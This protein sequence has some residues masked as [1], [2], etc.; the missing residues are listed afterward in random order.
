M[1]ATVLVVDDEPDI[2]RLL[3][4]NLQRA[5]LRP[6]TAATGRAAWEQL[7]AVPVPDLMLLDLTLP[8]MSGLEL[9]RQVRAD[10]RLAQLPVVMLTAR[11]DEVDRV[12]GF[13]VGADDYVPKPFHARE[14]L[15]R[16]QAIL[17]RTRGLPRP[18]AELE[19][20]RLR[21]HPGTGEASL[22]GAPL[23]LSEQ[24]RRLLSALAQRHGRICTREELLRVVWDDGA[25]VSLAAVDSAVKRL[26]RKLGPA[27]ETVE[28][29]RGVGHRLSSP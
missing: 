23:P 7:R 10:A 13:S 1:E 3:E 14:L 26:R 2:R 20:G 19:L 18:E 8:D 22:D 4:L 28:T 27:A 24:E 11:A 17:R 21:L 15:L 9:C 6:R 29:L 25:E 16:V 5:G 12:V